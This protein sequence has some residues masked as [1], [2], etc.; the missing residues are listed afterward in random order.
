[1][2]LTGGVSALAGAVVLGPRKGR[3]ERPDEFEAFQQ[4]L[5][6]LAIQRS[7]NH[8]KTCRKSGSWM[9]LV[10]LVPMK[11]FIYI[12]IIIYIYCMCVWSPPPTTPRHAVCTGIS[13]I[14][15][16]FFLTKL[17]KLYIYIIGSAYV[18]IYIHIHICTDG[19]L[20]YVGGFYQL[21]RLP[22]LESPE[23]REI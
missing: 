1:M 10:R 12:Y 6:L 15:F 18:Y 22:C 11:L 19:N 17:F 9:V 16:L 8:G 7:V 3:F 23:A 2:H 5:Q 13:S 4:T 20:M 14:N 21:L